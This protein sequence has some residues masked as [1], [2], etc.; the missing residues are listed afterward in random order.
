MDFLKTIMK[1]GLRSNTAGKNLD[2]AGFKDIL[3]KMPR[4]HGERYHWVKSMNLN[5]LLA[6]R[7]RL[8][9]IFDELSGIR[10]MNE[11]RWP[12]RKH[13]TYLSKI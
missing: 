7:L 10:E 6:R 4:I 11:K 1:E 9:N 12:G 13:S 8:G 3:T 5:R 2:I